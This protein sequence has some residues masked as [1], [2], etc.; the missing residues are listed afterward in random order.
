MAGL[1]A[2]TVR[3]EPVVS[4][5]TVRVRTHSTGCRVGCDRTLSAATDGT[6]CVSGK[7]HSMW[8][9][10]ALI[11]FEPNQPFFEPNRGVFTYPII[12]ILAE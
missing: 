4:Q 12:L 3:A 5:D 10:Y 6:Y 8:L 2:D 9:N 11:L 1:R 7:L